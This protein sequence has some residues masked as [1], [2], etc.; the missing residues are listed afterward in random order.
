M[1]ALL[2]KYADLSNWKIFFIT[3][4]IIRAVVFAFVI[5]LSNHLHNVILQ[6]DDSSYFSAIDN[7][8]NG[9]C[10]CYS[11]THIFAGRMPGYSILYFILRYVLSP[12]AATL[13]IIFSQFI[14]SCITAYVLC[15]LSY[16]LFQNKKAAVLTFLIYCIG[17]FPGIFDFWITGESFSISALIIALYL[18]YCAFE[19]QRLFNRNIFLSGLLIAWVIFLRPYVGMFIVV[20]P[21]F[22]LSFMYFTKKEKVKRILFTLVLFCSSFVIAETAWVG[23]NYLVL[24]RFIPLEDDIQNSYGKLYS[25]AWMKIDRMIFDWGED[26]AFFDKGTLGNYFRI[27]STWREYDFPPHLFNKVTA[28]NRDSL[29]ALKKMYMRYYYSRDTTG[30]YLLENKIINVAEKYDKDYVEHNKFHYFINK[31]IRSIKTL[32]VAG[33]WQYIPYKMDGHKVT[34]RSSLKILST[35][36]YF[37]VIILGIF[38]LLYCI[39]MKLNLPY[40]LLLAALSLSVIISLVYYTAT[41]EPRYF[42]HVFIILILFA[43]LPLRKAISGIRKK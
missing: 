25:H 41:E 9:G 16:K 26:A 5:F 38:G 15:L 32:I 13:F 36:L 42:V 18:L 40:V 34:V 28:Y 4:L 22:I 35:L 39:K 17:I 7:Y 2:N 27:D 37:S 1:K 8:F 23:R 10:F 14:L 6:P 33:G 29:I 43:P 19:E 31:P 30:D 24:H 21:C 20:F 11:G 12:N 3:A